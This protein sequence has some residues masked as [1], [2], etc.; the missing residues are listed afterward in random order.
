MGRRVV[1]TGI[2]PVTSVGL[3]REPFLASLWNQCCPAQPVPAPFRRASALHS[4][5]YVPLPEFSLADHGLHLAHENLRQPQDRMALLAAKLAFEDAGFS[6]VP[7]EGRMQVEGL[8]EAGV[9]LGVGLGGL[10]TAFESHL[11]H[12]LP[13]EMLGNLPDGRRPRFNRMVVPKTMTNAPAAWISI[14]FGLHGACHTLNASCA[15][16]T[17]AI[18]EAFRRIKDGYDR[19]VLAGGVEAMQDPTGF[20]MRGFDVLGVLTQAPDG[21]PRPFSRRRSGFFFAEGGACL[22]VLEDLEH[23]RQRGAAIYAELADYR[24]NSDASNIVQIDPSGQ[25]IRRLLGELSAGRKIDYLNAHGTGT[26]VNDEIE[27]H[28]IQRVFGGQAAQP[29]INSTK[30]LLGHTLGASGAIEAAV[31]ALAVAR[32]IVHGNLSDDPMPDLNLPWEPTQGRIENALSV[33]YGFGGH[34]AG[35]RFTNLASTGCWRFV[36]PRQRTK[37]ID[38]A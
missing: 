35:L 11:G 24:A 26:V 19:L 33:S 22:L 8:E 2:G 38:P 10:Q 6:V 17:C 1:I 13:P 29:W 23:A 30:G 31:T 32:G 15:S 27:A 34:N 36:G 12:A 25:Q 9:S 18:G 28:A 7:F 37:W 5:W 4:Q 3:G 21:R 14:G 20:F 16:G